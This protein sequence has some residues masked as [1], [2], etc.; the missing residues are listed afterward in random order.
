LTS[1]KR[2]AAVSN[3]A[4]TADAMI[5]LKDNIPSRTVP[6]VNYGLIAVCAMVFLVQLALD[7][8]GQDRIAEQF[9]MIPR[10]VLHPGE[11]VSVQ[12]QFREPNGRI[13]TD[14]YTMAESPIPPWLTLFTCIFLHGGWMHV[15]G[16][17]WVLYIFG[18]NVE[19]RLGH[20]GY[21]IFYLAAGV[22]A[23]AAHLAFN[24]DSPIPTVGASGAIAGVMGAYMLLYPHAQVL[25][26]VPIVVIMQI[27]VLPAPVFLGIWFVLQL[28][29]GALAASGAT[30]GV[31]WWAHIG[32]FVLGFAVAAILRALGRTSPPVTQ[33][34]PHTEHS[35]MYRYHRQ[36]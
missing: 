9:G 35:G 17:L 27:V 28:I 18:D 19:D 7:Q 36:R 29:Q 14:T 20:V 8:S 15:I 5:P 11:P 26:L 25:S 23:S 4:T 32:G 6:F 31:A 22:A 10:R 21:L 2:E 24:M 33:R 34:R 13:V 30:T 1:R 3:L 16:N 12:A